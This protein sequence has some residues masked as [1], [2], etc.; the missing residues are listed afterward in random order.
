[1]GN[2][3]DSDQTDPQIRGL[4]LNCFTD[5][6]PKLRKSPKQCFFLVFLASFFL[7][8]SIS[9]SI[10]I[11][12]LCLC[13][14]VNYRYHKTI[15]NISQEEINHCLFYASNI[16]KI[17]KFIFIDIWAA[18]WENLL[19]SNVK[20]KKISCMIIIQLISSFSFP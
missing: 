15:Q 14:S 9:I 10:Y 2:S 13:Y 19:S 16:S 18:S 12:I 4:A 5:L 3:A 7:T 17:Y 1:M 11:H 6:C 8:C 20:T